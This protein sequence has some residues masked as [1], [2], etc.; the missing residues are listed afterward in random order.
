MTGF[1]ATVFRQTALRLLAAAMALALAHF[2]VAAPGDVV[3]GGQTEFGRAVERALAQYRIAMATLESGGREQTAAEV[4]LFRQTWQEIID[5]F[6]KDRP[7]AF[8]DDGRYAATLLDVD[9]RLVGA[10]I[11]IDI[12]SRDAA[13]AALKPIGDILVRRP[14]T[15][16]QALLDGTQ[17]KG[18]RYTGE[19]FALPVVPPALGLRP[20]EQGLQLRV[21]PPHQDVAD[22]LPV[23]LDG[24]DDLLPGGRVAGPA[25]E[26]RDDRLPVHLLR[27]PRGRRRRSRSSV[28]RSWRGGPVTRRPPSD[29]SSS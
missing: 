5:R 7:V 1:V 26:H 23:R 28:W 27:E 17:P 4:Q 11:M 16:L 6:G 22:R 13:R 18:R 15:Q 25:G 10:M 19:V 12:G 9:V 24:C 21:R 8:S 14:Y 29:D 2:A 20:V 3:P